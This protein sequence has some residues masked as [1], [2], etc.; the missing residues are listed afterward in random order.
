MKTKAT[1]AGLMAIT[2]AMIGVLLFALAPAREASAQASVFEEFRLVNAGKNGS[3]SPKYDVLIMNTNN[4]PI[5]ISRTGTNVIDPTTF[6]DYPQNGTAKEKKKFLRRTRPA[7][8]VKLDSGYDIDQVRANITFNYP[9][10]PIEGDVTTVYNDRAEATYYGMCGALRRSG[11]NGRSNEWEQLNPNPPMD[12]D[13]RG[14]DT[15]RGRGSNRR[16]WSGLEFG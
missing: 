6:Q 5:V 12:R 2:I 1:I 4:N 14:E 13:G 8:A 10:P 16:G 11:Y 15:G 9:E 3:K 7:V